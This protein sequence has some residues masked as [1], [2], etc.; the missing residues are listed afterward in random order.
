MW[1][2]SNDKDSAQVS[3]ELPQDL[4]AFFEQAN[5]ETSQQSKFELS[6][7]QKKV[8]SVLRQRENQPYSHEFDQY[9]RRETLKSATQVNCAEIQQQVVECLRG[10]NLTL[11]NRCETEIKTHTKCVETQ[12]RALKLLFYEDC[13]DI[14]QCKKIRYVVDKLF[15]DNYGQ[16]GEQIDDED[17][18]MRFD[19]GVESAFAKIWR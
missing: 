14:D 19:S 16:Y 4:G 11:S 18:R 17:T 9:K 12:T 8:N 5:P 13:V 3:K 6:P 7:H 15:V 10:W 2:F 1:P